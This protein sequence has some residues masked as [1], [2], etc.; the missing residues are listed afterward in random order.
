[1]INKLK[2]A[3][4]FINGHKESYMK[5]ILIP[6]DFSDCSLNAVKYGTELAKVIEAEIILCHSFGIIVPGVTDTLHDVQ[7]KYIEEKHFDSELNKIS[8]EISSHLDKSKNPLKCRHFLIQSGPI[9]GIAHFTAQF[10]PEYILMGTVGSNGWDN[11]LGSTTVGVIR[12]INTPVIVVPST[13]VFVPPQN[14][15]IS[16][17]F[18]LHNIRCIKQV[19]QFT[20]LFNAMVMVGHVSTFE[21]D[22][23]G[24][25]EKMNLLRDECSRAGLNIQFHTILSSRPDEAILD[26]IQTNDFQLIVLLKERKDFFESL[27]HK[28]FI[29]E[30]VL[31]SKK[32][33]LIMADQ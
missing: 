18:P 33:L 23:S 11:V 7:Q 12:R 27:F 30:L 4:T 24:G 2:E 22:Q 29:K 9:E 1:L 14:I 15:F 21:E 3:L 10:A 17:D 32:P 26:F 13:V 6:V 31:E 5:K 28:S 25:R 19:T 8:Q 20:S 16:V